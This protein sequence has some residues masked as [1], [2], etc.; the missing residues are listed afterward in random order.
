MKIHMIQKWWI[1][2]CAC[3]LNTLSIKMLILLK[4]KKQKLCTGGLISYSD[5]L[6]AIRPITENYYKKEKDNN[7]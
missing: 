2:I 6:Q 1:F 3:I 4:K 7:Y 5:F